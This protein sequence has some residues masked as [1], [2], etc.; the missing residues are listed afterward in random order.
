MASLCADPGKRG[1]SYRVLIKVANGKRHAVR[2]GRVNK[3]IAE[4]ARLMIE[5]LEAAVAAGHS[6]DR[7]TAEWVGRLGDEIH[8]RLVRAGL[9]PA[10]EQASTT[11][12]TLGQHLEKLFGSL[13]KQKPTTARNY[14]RA[15]R[16][17]E[18]F[19]GKDRKLDSITEG[20]ADA[21]KRWLLDRYAPASAS[22]DLRRARQFLKAAVRQ[23]LIPVNPFAEV[24]CGSQIN[25]ERIAYV[26]AA[27]V[28][29]VIAACPDNDWRLTFALPRYAGLRFPS[30]VKDLKWADIDWENSRF[31]VRQK[32]LEHH[33][34]RATRTVPIF[35]EL[36]THLERAFRERAAGAVY[37]LPRAR[38][39]TALS[40]HAKRLVT[41]AGVTLWP[42]L[43]V[44]MRGSCSDDLER[45]GVPEKAINAWI[46]NTSRVRQR[47]YHA[48]RPEDWASVTGKAAQIPARATP[49]S[50]HQEPSTL[51]ESR[52]KTLQVLTHA[53]MY[54]P[55]Q[56]SNLRPTV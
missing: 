27:D 48:V 35:A 34:G 32:K 21:Y 52:E 4:T 56:G 53:E 10:R 38:T 20:D 19:F 47:H 7:E 22:V 36:R 31:T 49:V 16:L 29:L 14:A 24:T 44:N 23:R 18:E 55:R 45:R 50:G 46:G 11:I 15:R 33:P 28:E 9:V 3:R 30:E 54:Y 43:F 39:T 25:D 6:P 2:L 8:G 5:S 40:T 17:L 41:K 37:V 1:T 26:T 12:T 13:G 42:K 51:H